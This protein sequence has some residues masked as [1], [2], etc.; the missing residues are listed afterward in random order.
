MFLS[1]ANPAFLLNAPAYVRYADQAS[2]LAPNDSP[3]TSEPTETQAQTPA[4]TTVSGDSA[5]TPLTNASVAPS[6]VPA[7]QATAPATQSS[8]ATNLPGLAYLA[9]ASSPALPTGMNTFNPTLSAQAPSTAAPVIAAANSAAG[10]DQ[11]L[12][13]TGA[14]FTSY[15]DASAYADTR[16]IVYGQTHANN[17]TL[18]DAAIQDLGAYGATVTIDAS[19]PA[20]SMYLLWAVNSQGIS[21]PIAINQ[22]TAWWMGGIGQTL[23]TAQGQ[24]TVST[25]VGQTIS[26]Y[27]RNLSNG[28]ATPQSWVYLQPT[29]GSAG[30]WATVTSVNPYKVDFTAAAPGTYQVWINNGLGGQYG[31]SEVTQSG[32]PVLL[33]V[34][35]SAPTWSGATINV[36]N[37]GAKGDGVADDGKAI[38]S[39]IAA[40][41]WNSGQTLYFPAGTYLVS[42]GE[43]LALP[44]GIRVLGDGPDKSKIVFTGP[45]ASSDQPFEF[46]WHDNNAVNVE[47]N[48]LTLQYTGPTTSSEP[49]VLANSGSNIT[50]KNVNLLAQNLCPLAWQWSSNLTLQNSQVQGTDINA[51]ATHDEFIN[52]VQFYERYGA[53]SAIELW[54]THNVSITNCTVRD[55][56]DSV[57]ADNSGSGQGRFLEYNLIWGP[58]DN[59]YVANNTTINLASPFAGN[60]GEQIN[61]EGRWQAAF[62][63][64]SAVTSNTLTIAPNS[65]GG[66]SFAVGDDVVVT[67]GAGLGQMRTV[68]AVT[69]NHGPDGSVSS[70]TLTLDKPWNVLPDTTTSH[71][72]VGASA[73]NSVFYQNTLSDQAGPNGA[74]HLDAACAFLIY[75]GGYGVVFDSNTAKNLNGGASAMSVDTCNPA[76]FN[77]IINNNFQQILRGALGPAGFY[78]AGSQ[79]PNNIGTIVRDNMITSGGLGWDLAQSPLG[80]VVLMVMEHNG[81]TAPVPMKVAN[82]PDVLI[83]NNTFT[84]PGGGAAPILGASTNVAAPTAL[85]LDANSSATVRL[86]NNAYVGFAP[87]NIYGS[88]SPTTSS[89]ATTLAAPYH[90]LLATVTAGSS[91][92]IALPLWND[93]TS[94]I[95]WAGSTDA[96]W[97]TLQ[98]SSGNI[99]DE[100]SP[101]SAIL[102]ANAADLSPGNYS[103]T[104]TLTYAANNRRLTKSFHVQL[105]VP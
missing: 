18:T 80:P 91:T 11:S 45:V 77:E 32:T 67:D 65:A 15:S 81:I 60:Y 29:D 103:A 69:L 53:A 105:T 22:T 5:S 95:T 97:L 16:F 55:Y 31:W 14:Q 27:G 19:E 42:G 82:G 66:G 52:N 39:A 76:Y 56:D 9:P 54:A 7:T 12:A 41:S 85:L 63:T 3:I 74:A 83:R 21:A 96:P 102:I 8:A 47:V 38:L 48:A 35:A 79:D 28:T 44:S 13:L 6:T 40:L 90:V 30:Q 17:G 24:T 75:C 51:L 57:T 68:T 2:Q 64:P 36:K 20:N 26:V 25:S 72:M 78:G 86:R 59:Q 71:V 46:G 58:I 104:V 92:Q 1:V 23:Q 73:S 62:G 88:S 94:A 100:N 99:A 89:A 4:Q 43:Q 84:A 70:A 49:L 98:S 10:P 87:Q 101:A 50:I 93:G 61:I 33:H 34:A 37:Y